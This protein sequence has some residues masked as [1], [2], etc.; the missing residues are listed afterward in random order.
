M[1]KKV[2]AGPHECMD[3]LNSKANYLRTNDQLENFHL[4]NVMFGF[5]IAR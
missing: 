5:R 4:K 2:K 3:R 1:K